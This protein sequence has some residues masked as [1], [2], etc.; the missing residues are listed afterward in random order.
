MAKAKD[1]QKQAAIYQ[2]ALQIV[3]REGFAGLKMSQVAREAGVATGTVY[4]YFANKE[5]LINDLYLQLKRDSAR[6]FLEGYDPGQPFLVGFETI[7]FNYFNTMLERPEEMAFL[8]QYYRSPYLRQAVKDETDKLLAPIFELL[9]RGKQERLVADIDTSLLAAQL[10]GG[11]NELV[12]W[13]VMGTIELTP[14]KKQQAFEMAWN[15]IK[16]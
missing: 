16:R 4:L 13:H 9:E 7:W 6:N 2:A 10:S 14:G 5:E 1:E 15:S 12:R 11:M 8:E 3:L